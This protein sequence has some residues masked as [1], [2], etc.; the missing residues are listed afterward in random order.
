M[1]DQ[2]RPPAVIL[3]GGQSRRMGLDKAGLKL[4]AEPLALQIAERL[5]PQVSA[6]YLNAP[7]RHPLGNR[8]PLLSDAHPDRPGPLAGVLAGLK[9]FAEGAGGVTHVLTTPC[10]TPFLPSDLVERLV[11]SAERGTI[12]MASS[13]GRTHPTTALWPLTLSDDLEEW[14]ADPAHRRV[15]DFAARHPARAV[16]FPPFE[17]PLGLVDPFFNINTPEDLATAQAILGSGTA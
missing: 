3:A 6:V 1:S 13:G 7:E 9:R 11:A 15:F 2:I 5:K 16:D 4:G 14:L 10:D 17:G 12:V 8:I